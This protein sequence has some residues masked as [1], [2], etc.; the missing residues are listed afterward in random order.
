MGRIR[1]IC[2]LLIFVLACATPVG[3]K[4]TN[5]P[6][7]YRAVTASALTGDVPSP[8]ARQF[9]QRLALAEQF[10]RRPAS[11]IE[12]I[13]CGLG[14]PDEHDRLF[15]L[16]ELSFIEGRRAH[17]QRHFMAAAVY[18]Y[19]FLFPGDRDF[20]PS[21]FDPRLRLA[22]DIYNRALANG[23][24]A[25]DGEHI[26]LSPRRIALPF[27]TLDLAADRFGYDGYRLSEFNSVD[28]YQIRGLRNDY[29]KPGIGAPLVARVNEESTRATNLWVATRAK[30]PVTAV[31][32][33]ERWREG[34]GG[35]PMSGRIE[36]R[37]ID[38]SP[39]TAIG[40]LSVPLE[41]DPSTALAYN[42]QGSPLWDFEI[43]G[44]RRGDFD[45]LG[46]KEEG[47]LFFIAPWRPGRIPVVFVHGTASSPARWAQMFNELQGDPRIASRYQFWF[48]IYNSGNPIAMSAM[49][50]RENLAAAVKQ[51]DPEGKD[52]ALRQMVVI[53][54]SQGGLLAKMT[55]VN[56]GNKFWETISK[57]PFETAMLSAESKNM[58]RRSLFIEPLP[59]VSRVIFIATPHH[60]SYVAEDFLGRIARRFITL[61]GNL[62]KI[63]ME[64][65]QLKLVDA[66][67]ATIRIPTAVDNMD[68]GNPFLRTLYSL[69]IAPGVK[70]NSVIAVK[71]KQTLEKGNDGVV[72]YTSAHIEGVESELVVRSK[73]S[74]QS[75]PAAIEEVRR[76]LDKHAGIAG[77]T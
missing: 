31:V 29:R 11:A 76:I 74:C 65:A 18:A 3:V 7:V 53:G 12:A 43:A 44:F 73:H 47:R 68:W 42:L 24:R 58:L 25:A 27:T 6:A 39:T 62:T 28:D 51:L 75:N 4:R 23:L 72:R 48:F 49:R 63:G 57:H 36:V 71:R 61:P 55:V 17:D 45:I 22:M 41:S 14:G 21:P 10:K 5:E 2:P 70:A 32:K 50:L 9:L 26:D 52:P 33:F 20:E 1:Y 66:A 30:V 46:R 8:F 67:R 34:F 64:V 16:A 37:D 59:F 69:P 35:R 54:H 13:R 15:A 40:R 56:S 60:G 19:A 38:M 77:G